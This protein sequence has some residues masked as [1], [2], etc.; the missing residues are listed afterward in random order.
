MTIG[1]QIWEN[2][3]GQSDSFC[4]NSL[5]PPKQWQ[6]TGPEKQYIFRSFLFVFENDG[7]QT[8]TYPFRSRT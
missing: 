3:G 1:I 6:H 8:K 2:L 7:H 5:M 4:R